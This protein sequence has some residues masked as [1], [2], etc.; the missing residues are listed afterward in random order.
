MIQILSEQTIN[1]LA[2][3]E[4]IHSPSQSIKELFENSIDA[5]A[6]EITIR[7]TNNCIFLQN[8]N[9]S[10]QKDDHKLLCQ[11]FCTSKIR[12][13]QDLSNH[14]EFG[15]RGE[16][17]AAMSYVSLVTC[18][19]G[20]YFSQHKDGSM[21]KFQDHPTD[22]QVTSFKIEF[23]ELEIDNDA[24]KTIEILAMINF[25]VNTYISFLNINMKIGTYTNIQ[26]SIDNYLQNQTKTIQVSGINIDGQ[27]FFTQSNKQG[28]L[29]I[30]NRIIYTKRLLNLTQKLIQRASKS[31]MKVTVVFIVNIPNHLIDFNCHPQK[32]NVLIMNQLDVEICIENSIERFILNQTKVQQKIMI[33]QPRSDLQLSPVLKLRQLDQKQQINTQIKLSIKVKKD[34]RQNLS[35]NIKQI[36]FQLIPNINIIGGYENQWSQFIIIQKNLKLYQI[37]FSCIWSYL[38][39]LMFTFQ[40]NGMAVINPFINIHQE[41]NSPELGVSQGIIINP[42]C[43][44]PGD[45]FS[46]IYEQRKQ[47]LVP[48]IT[49]LKQQIHNKNLQGYYALFAK[50]LFNVIKDDRDLLFDI[51]RESDISIMTEIGDQYNILKFFNR[52]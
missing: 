30:N 5:G 31:T 16:A 23:N 43:L 18:I 13:F 24:L 7:L 52:L 37:D 47:D 9:S 51:I 17:L 4:I 14:Q 44:L 48:N 49:L 46:D 40:N 32:S 10:I 42:L 26:E 20:G 39:N 6:T 21:I 36:K 29:V 1:K 25:Q 3:G 12:D 38:N 34:Y 19:S 45:C 27:I 50:K 2:A 11:R 28:V 35:F 8:N 22:V 33:K 15:F 41:V